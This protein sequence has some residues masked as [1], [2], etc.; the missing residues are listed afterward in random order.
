MGLVAFGKLNFGQQVWLAKVGALTYPLYLLHGHIG[1][2]VFHRIGPLFS[3]KFVL[4]GS[5]LAA[6]LL[7]SYLIATLVEKPLGKWLGQQLNRLLKALGSPPEEKPV[8]ASSVR[9]E[10]LSVLAR[11]EPQEERRELVSRPS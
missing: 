1:Y 3:N 9:E 5:L 4:L 11:V 2:V 10:P 8:A 6:M 7:A